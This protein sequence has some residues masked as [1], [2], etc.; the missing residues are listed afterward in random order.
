LAY[1]HPPIAIYGTIWILVLTYWARF[2]PL[3]ATPIADGLAQLDPV[4]AESALVA[5]ASAWRAFWRVQLPLVRSVAIAAGLVVMMYT[6]RE[7][8]SAVF[9]QSSQVKMAMVAIF[10]YWDEGS[11]EQAAALSTVIV[12][13][14]VTVFAI[15]NRFQ[16]GAAWRR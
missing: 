8:L 12:L 4:L 3:A 7:L 9:L 10:D 15:A 13:I 11:L 16:T 2:Y 5:G 6:M 14:S 1:V